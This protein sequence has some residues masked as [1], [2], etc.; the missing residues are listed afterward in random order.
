[1][2]AGQDIAELRGD[3]NAIAILSDTAF[4]HVTD[5]EFLADL[6][7]MDAFA[8]VGEGRI[9]SDDEKPAQLRQRGNNVLTDTIR[10]I[11]LLRIAG[12]IIE[13]QN[14]DGRPVRQRQRQLRFVPLIA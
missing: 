10:E 4:E 12:H 2:P 13:R 6:L 8:F 11:V 1:V 7:E 9:A 14:R 3:A 5:P